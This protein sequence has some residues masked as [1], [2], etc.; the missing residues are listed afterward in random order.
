M[1]D[2]LEDLTMS[3]EILS[4]RNQIK[5]TMATLLYPSKQSPSRK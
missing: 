2:M 4:Y 1:H 3:I 5:N